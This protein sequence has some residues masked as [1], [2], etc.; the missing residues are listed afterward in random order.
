MSLLLSVLPLRDVCKRDP[1]DT[2]VLLCF[3]MKLGSDSCRVARLTMGCNRATLLLPET[4][5]GDRCGFSGTMSLFAMVPVALSPLTWPSTLF[6]ACM[7]ASAVLVLRDVSDKV[8]AGQLDDGDK[9]SS[10]KST[11]SG[12]HQ[13]DQEMYIEIIHADDD[14]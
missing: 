11:F 5:G 3:T 12:L 10:N 7:S 4:L 2:T 9:S 1:P 13:N 8:S 6:A 14:H